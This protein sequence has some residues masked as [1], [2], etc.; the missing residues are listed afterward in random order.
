MAATHSPLRGFTW[1][2]ST[3]TFVPQHFAKNASVC[4]PAAAGSPVLVPH[5]VL[6]ACWLA[7][8]GGAAAAQWAVGASAAPCGNVDR[9]TG[10]LAVGSS[11]EPHLGPAQQS[12]AAGSEPD[13]NLPQV[14]TLV[15]CG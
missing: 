8:C 15:E 13:S 5:A 11:C 3:C 7:R 1:H 12:S 10:P 14:N 4:S 9:T 6:M 2:A